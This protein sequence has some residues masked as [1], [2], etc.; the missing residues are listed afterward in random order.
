MSGPGIAFADIPAGCLCAWTG[1]PGGGWVIERPSW[2]GRQRVLPEC[3]PVLHHPPV[4]AL[5]D[6]AATT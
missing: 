3:C 6:P 5:P 1:A 4:K 2:Y